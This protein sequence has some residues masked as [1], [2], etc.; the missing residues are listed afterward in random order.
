MEKDLS[1][2]TSKFIAHCG[3]HNE[4]IPENSLPAF[5]NAVKHGYAIELDVSPTLDGVAVTHYQ[6]VIKT[7]KIVELTSLKE[8]ELANQKIIN[9][10]HH[11]PSLSEVFSLVNGKTPIFIDIKQSKK[12]VGIFEERLLNLIKNYKGQVA[13]MAFNP[14]VVKWFK[15]NAPDIPRGLLTTIWRKN[16][17]GCPNSALVRNLL[18]HNTL[19]KKGDAD[20]LSINIDDLP[21]KLPSKFDNLPILGWTVDSKQCYEEKKQYVDNIIFENFLP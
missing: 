9:T 3:L 5:E 4:T 11:I 6:T 18:S 13:V 2:L 1:F 10:P 19:Y 20:F 7:H 8:S 14:Y 16:M 12:K 17:L 21:A 15:E